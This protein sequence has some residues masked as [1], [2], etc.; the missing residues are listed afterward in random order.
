MNIRHHTK[1]FSYKP[2]YSFPDF[3]IR[4]AGHGP[5]YTDDLFV[6]LRPV[7]QPG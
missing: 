1:V 3:N 2:Q 4:P 6:V 5:V 7:Q